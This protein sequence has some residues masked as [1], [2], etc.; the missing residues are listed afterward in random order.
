M[1][2]T[3]GISAD[4][5]LPGNMETISPEYQCYPS[6]LLSGHLSHSFLLHSH[7]INLS[8]RFFIIIQLLLCCHKSD[9]FTIFTVVYN[10]ESSLCTHSDMDLQY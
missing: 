2:I 10:T 1:M 6:V 8:T 9:T 3:V 5:I 7:R 4:R